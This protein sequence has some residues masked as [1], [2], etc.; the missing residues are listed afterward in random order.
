MRSGIEMEPFVSTSER[1]GIALLPKMPVAS[2]PAISPPPNADARTS[3]KITLRRTKVDDM[4]G[5]C[6]S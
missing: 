6:L 1:I 2:V 3:I 5:T 4:V